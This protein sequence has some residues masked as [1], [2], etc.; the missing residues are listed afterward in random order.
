MS[1]DLT[2]IIR[3]H[4]LKNALDF[5]KASAGSVVGKV[6][7]EMPDCKKDM[8]T[9]MQKINEIVTEVNI[10]PKD[11]IESELKNYSFVEKPKEEKKG[12]E[13]PNAEMGKVITRFPPE[14]S[15]YP[16]IGHAKAAFL[17][18]EIAKQ[19]N[20]KFILR[21]DDT[22]P[23]KEEQNFVEAIKEGL[24][25]LGIKWDAE[26]YT[27]D[28]IEN[29]YSHC[30]GLI[31]RGNA[32]VCTC[33]QEQI[34][35][36]RASMKDC[37]CRNKS[38]NEQEQTWDAMIKGKVKE[39]QAILRFKG[40]VKSL[41]TVMR[42][43]TLARIINKK[44]Y[45]HAAKY[46]VWPSYDLAVVIMDAL[47]S[48]T[49]P[50][51]TKEYELRD[52]LYYALCDALGFKRPNLIGFSRLEIKNAPISKRLLK[53]LVEEGKVDGW[54]DPRLPT[55]AGL[56][57]RG[58]LPEAIRN[59]VLSFGLSKV[60]SEPTW[61]RLLVENRKLLDSIAK[62]Y[63][64]VPDPVELAIDL[65]SEDVEYKIRGQERKVKINGNIYIP[66]TDF[67]S[68]TK[69]EVFALK[70]LAFVKLEGKALKRIEQN[71]I[72]EK[73]IQWVSAADNIK[74]EVWIP[75]DLLENGEY[76]KKSLE[77]VK[78]YCESACAHIKE[79]ETTQFERFGFCRLDKKEKDKLVFVYSC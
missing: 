77:V 75:H 45:R 76:N 46:K 9:T 63:F 16:H 52:E 15:G 56:K 6:I 39:G 61:E 27:S 8:K 50:M 47:E 3:K 57:R 64:F 55:L 67:K 4:A 42:D 71:E 21:F 79:G 34:S 22:N 14:P 36:L 19:F 41:N 72:P 13:I 51:R 10:M 69:D 70:D 33:K 35:E 43:P 59:F 5:S 32:Y 38:I 20:G 29:I 24:T 31:A 30:T 53:P 54:D 23:E 11:K 66:K 7:A 25:W 40:D 12:F 58:V 60:E 28:N 26:T 48:I 44:H 62:H 73:K 18:Y 74:C 1:N 68:L 78:G 37:S 17:D 2:S 65:K 49:H